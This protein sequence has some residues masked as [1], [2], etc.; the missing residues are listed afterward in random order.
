MWFVCCSIIAQILTSRR[1]ISKTRKLCFLFSWIWISLFFV[2]EKLRSIVR[3]WVDNCRRANCWRFVAPPFASKIQQYSG[4]Y[5]KNRQCLC[6]LSFFLSHWCAYLL[7]MFRSRKL[8]TLDVSISSSRCVALA[9]I[10]MQSTSMVR[11]H[12]SLRRF[13]RHVNASTQFDCCWRWMPTR[14]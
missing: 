7:V 12:W 1:D 8:R 13:R 6:R 11:L 14:R 4:Q 2:L 5:A 10:S 3:F 9:P